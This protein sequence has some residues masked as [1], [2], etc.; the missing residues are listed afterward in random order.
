MEVA[1]AALVHGEDDGSHP[2]IL[3]IAQSSPDGGDQLE[4]GGEIQENAL[5]TC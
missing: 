4:K 5:I 3:K 2:I 1:F